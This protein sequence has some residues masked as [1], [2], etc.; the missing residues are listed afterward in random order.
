MG[1]SL[2]M[3]RERLNCGGGLYQRGREQPRP[4]LRAPVRDDPPRSRNSRVTNAATTVAIV[5]TVALAFVW[6][7]SGDPVPPV[8]APL[9]SPAAIGADA[10][11]L[12]DTLWQN[13]AGEGNAEEP[14]E[15]GGQARPRRRKGG[16]GRE[17]GR[18]GA[19]GQRRSGGW[20]GEAGS[21]A[22]PAEAR[23]R[24]QDPPAAAP[25]PEPAVP[26]PAEFAIG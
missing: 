9:M 6:T 13:G 24:R 15:P 17:R 4:S 26:G 18:S 8:P 10:G 3:G 2:A 16:H 5:L 21:A 20:R 25:E 23:P 11:P 19:S 14:A 12:D 22:P 1:G 7:R